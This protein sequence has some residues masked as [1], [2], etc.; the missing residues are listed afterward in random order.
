MMRALRPLTALAMASWLSGCAA[1]EL[2]GGLAGRE[3]PRLYQAR[4]PTT[5]EADLP[6]LDR[7]LVI[8]VPSA[9]P[10]LNTA[11]IALRPTYTTVDYFGGAAWAEV[12]PVMVQG[13]MID[14]FE[15]S[16]RIEVFGPDLV[17]L[18]ADYALLTEIRDFQAEYEDM[19]SA[20]RIRVRIQ[21]RLV[22]LPRRDSIA[23]TT[24]LRVLP[25]EGTGIEAIVDTFERA[26]ADAARE[27]VAW[28]LLQAQRAG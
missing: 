14:A 25:A 11:R 1:L 15:N 9:T 23:G 26:L 17:G 3:P 5:F 27:L 2:A 10:G 7:S 4:A 12:L 8:E 22:R 20:P 24:A 28:T 13:V 6:S 18:R 21:A 16:G 19:R